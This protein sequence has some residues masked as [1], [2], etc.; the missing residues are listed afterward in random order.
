MPEAG[1]KILSHLLLKL[2]TTDGNFENKKYL[3]TVEY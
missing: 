1:K 2:T 3:F